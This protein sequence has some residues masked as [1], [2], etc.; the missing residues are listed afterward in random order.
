M[1]ALLIF[2]A[3][4]VLV[5][6]ALAMVISM[7]GEPKRAFVVIDSSF[8]MR[9]VW[10]QVPGALDDLDSQGYSAFA[11]ATEKDSIHSWQ[12]KLQ[13]RSSGAFAPCDFSKIDAYSEATEADE[14]V[15]ITTGGSCPTD[16]LADWR[17]I[18]LQP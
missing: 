16:A 5:F 17:V 7:S 11:L 3:G 1:K 10:S 2:L 9:Q 15:L 14:R 4:L 12:E 13:F 18:A 8:P 6:G